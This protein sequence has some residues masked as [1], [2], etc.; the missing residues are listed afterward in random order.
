MPDL[1]PHEFKAALMPCATSGSALLSQVFEWGFTERETLRGGL[2][3]R[4]TQLV[5][6]P[7]GQ[8]RCVNATNDTLYAPI[9]DNQ[10]VPSA[11]PIAWRQSFR[12]LQSASVTCSGSD[13]KM[14]VCGLPRS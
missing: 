11:S 9:V 3:Q 2:P 14:S 12:W 1:G 6:T 5:Q 4:T 10:C 13:A 7:S 8:A